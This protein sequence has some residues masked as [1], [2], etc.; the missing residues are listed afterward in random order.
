[1]QPVII[2]PCTLYHADCLDVLPHLK[3]VDAVVTDPPYG[4]GTLYSSYV[5][6]PKELG[7]LVPRFMEMCLRLAKKVVVTPGVAN[8][9]AYPKYDWVLAWVNMAG[10]GSGPWGFCCWQPILVYGKDPFLYAGAG[11]RPDVYQQCK[12]EVAKNG[13]PT[14]KPTNVMCWLIQRT[15]GEGETILDPFMGSGTTG[16]ACIRTGRRLI[17]IEIDKGYFDIACDRIRRELD[18]FT[19]P[20]DIEHNHCGEIEQPELSINETH[21]KA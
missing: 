4:N 3:G 21:T 12:N 14:P 15:T 16:I 17:G 11:R 6:T 5:D 1:M 13:H 9:G 18:Q 20:I 10:V 19:L 2:G 7:K 8:I